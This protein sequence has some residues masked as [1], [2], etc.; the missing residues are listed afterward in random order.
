MHAETF[1]YILHGLAYERKMPTAQTPAHGT[2]PANRS[3]DAPGSGRSRATLGLNADEGFGW[4]NEFHASHRRRA[5]LFG[6]AAQGYQRR[7]SGVRTRRRGAAVFLGESTPAA[8]SIAA[9][10]PRCP[11]PLD[12]PVYVTQRRRK[13]MRD[14]AVSDC[15]PSPN[16]T[17]PPAWR[18]PAD[19]GNFDFRHWDPV[20]VAPRRARDLYG[21]GWEWTSTIFAPFPAFEPFPF[22]QNYSEPFFDDQ[23]YV[24]KGASPRTAACF[25][26]PSF[27]NW[28]R[29]VVS[30]HLCRFPA[31]RVLMYA[32][33][34]ENQF[35]QDVRC[36]LTRCAAEDAAVQLLLRRCGLRAF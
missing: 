18:L 22:Y 9:C 32:Q 5:G 17:A 16:S 30:L 6:V 7:V 12:C 2:G 11:L 34:L 23:H 27:R 21:N 24:L 26:R 28:F 25:L 10:S 13:P 35:A 29:P 14:G 19:D 15:S 3:T 20:P 8:G 36:G 33:A 31:G 4:D 1:A